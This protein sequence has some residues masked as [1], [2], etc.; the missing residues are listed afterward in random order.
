MNQLFY[1]FY[2]SNGHLN[3]ILLI[4][5]ALDCKIGANDRHRY[6][7]LT[8]FVVLGYFP[9]SAQAKKKPKP[10][11]EPA[12]EPIPEPS[13]PSEKSIPKPTTFEILQEI[14]APVKK[15]APKPKIR[16]KIDVKGILPK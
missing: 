14:A 2:C 10:R 9:A 4:K 7:F 1:N 16:E 3:D 6:Y 12:P 8:F 13:A 11:L 15:A 5:K